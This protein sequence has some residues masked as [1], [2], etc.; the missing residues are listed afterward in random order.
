MA[1][2]ALS[3]ALRQIQGSSDSRRL[4]SSGRIPGVV[5]GHGITPT[6]VSIDSKA[7]RLALNT[8]AGLNALISLDVEGTKHLTL[9]RAIQKH[10]VRN[11][12]AHV[13]FQVVSRN[14]MMTVEVPFLIE[15]EAEGVIKNG[16]VIEHVLNSL[17]ISAVPGQ[18][19]DH[20]KVDITNLGLDESIRVKDLD[21]PTGV[22]TE[23]DGEE[24]IVVGKV[25][26]AELDEPEDIGE[27]EG[28]STVEDGANA[29]EA[30]QG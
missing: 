11:T 3:A 7:L 14:E 28:S 1:E 22:T 2:I 29:S 23:V 17:T 5:Y 6:S 20:I 9:A 21:L 18:I 8:D 10:P 19:P 25:T 24:P 16:G 12:V 13:D 15:G 30:P 27:G 4:R 26:R